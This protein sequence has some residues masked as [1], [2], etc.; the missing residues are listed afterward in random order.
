MK[1]N[2]KILNVHNDSVLAGLND[3]PEQTYINL[4]ARNIGNDEPIITATFTLNSETDTPTAESEFINPTWVP[5]KPDFFDFTN[6]AFH[7]EY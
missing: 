3:V 7:Q 2:L 1:K 5:F 6:G 4:S